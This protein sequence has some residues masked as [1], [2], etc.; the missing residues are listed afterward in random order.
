MNSSQLARDTVSLALKRRAVILTILFVVLAALVVISNSIGIE[1]VGLKEVIAAI[2]DKV[3]NGFSYRN[4]IDIVVFDLRLP[5]VL[6]A[7]AAG[8]GLALAGTAT[9][10]VLL[11]PLVSPM[12]LGVSAGASF[13]A[14]LAMVL[15]VDL[16]GTGRYIIMGN[17]FVMATAAM[18]IAYGVA[19]IKRTS[20]ET[21]ILAGVAVGYIFTGLVAILQYVAKEEDLRS[22]VFWMM[23]S[24]WNAQ[25]ELLAV[26]LPIIGI[27]FLVLMKMAWDLNAV[28]SGE[29]VAAS[30][31]VPVARVRYIALIIGALS[32]A[33]VVSFTG[34]IGFIGLMSPHIARI[35]IGNDH[36]Y[37][38]P[39][40]A[41][42]GGIV[43]LTADTV[44]RSIVWPV[45]IPVGIMT[46]LMG[47]PF[48]I[49]LLWRRGKDWWS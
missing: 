45:E 22:L 23:G 8:M 32:T 35:I 4:Q 37:L 25:L 41:L 47:G 1:S 21:I 30:L 2:I 24:L 38:V 48:F 49:Y 12:I 33:A 14:S 31:G 5:R 39:A 15:G 16:V 43:L 27:V 44:A 26:I 18:F 9:Q 19:R 40:S 3:M 36:R 42:V 6:L 46:A 20:K 29:D 10:G 11:N 13:G 28:A 17:A 7:V 34:V